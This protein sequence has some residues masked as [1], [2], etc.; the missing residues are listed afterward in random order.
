MTALA[1][2]ALASL[3]L[4]VVSISLLR[5]WGAATA[6]ATPVPFV[7]A[8]LGAG[9]ATIFLGSLFLALLLGGRFQLPAPLLGG[10]VTMS[11]LGILRG[12]PRLASGLVRR[13]CGSLR[14]D[15][16]ASDNRSIRAGIDLTL[17]FLYGFV[18]FGIASQVEHVLPTPLLL[19]PLVA[20][21]P[22]LHALFEPYLVALTASTTPAREA[23]FASR[24]GGLPDELDRLTQ[25]AGVPSMRLVLIPG[26]L[27]NAYVVGVGVST[28]LLIGQGV[29]DRLSPR[30]LRALLAHEIGHVVK[31]HT[32]QFLMLSCLSSIGTALLL[33]Q[34]FALW[35]A[36]HLLAGV[37]L[38][39]AGGAV[40]NG[41]FPGWIRRRQEF[42]A[43]R[44][45]AQLLGGATVADSL[46]ALG[47]VRNLDP[48]Q[49]SLFYPSTNDRIRAV[50]A[51]NQ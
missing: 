15:V 29:V 28:R 44:F 46:T 32:W 36:G 20:F 18:V 17:A 5:I 26:R 45:A 38:A 11:L 39:G 9:G 2:I 21:L 31:R 50:S 49:G 7:L 22:L 6:E 30:Q 33:I 41:L 23:R 34:V 40:I 10:F 14:D 37:I 1:V 25:A 27:A 35:K 42:E 24:Y 48:G 3:A 47:R 4:A 13:Y 43:D 19:V 51:I 16:A 12:T 8:F